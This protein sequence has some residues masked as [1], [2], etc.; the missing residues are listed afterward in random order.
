MPVHT[1]I[2]VNKFNSVINQLSSDKML[3]NDFNLDKR[4]WLIW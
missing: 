3:R 4:K 1:I 2:F